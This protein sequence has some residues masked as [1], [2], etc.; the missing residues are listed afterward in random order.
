M[1]TIARVLITTT[2]S[3]LIGL[4]NIV[5]ADDIDIYNTSRFAPY[6]PYET[7]GEIAPPNPNYP[8]ILFIVDASWSM[9]NAD[10]GQV[11][12]R[13]SRLRTAF[14][15]ILANSTGVN[16]ALMRFSHRHSGARVLYP[17]SPI[18]YARDSVEQLVNTLVLD[19]WTPSVHA[20]LEGALYYRGDEVHFGR[21]RTAHVGYR[22]HRNER[23]SRVSHP[24]SYIGGEVV[25]N[26]QCTDANPD[27]A[28]CITE[29]IIGNALY[30]SPIHHACQS[31]HIIF[32]SDGAASEPVDRGLATDLIE[33]G[34]TADQ[35]FTCG[36]EIAHFLA[37]KDQSQSIAG[38]NTVTTHT[39]GFNTSLRSLEN[40]AAAGNGN[41][42]ESSSAAD[43][44]N[45]INE[46]ISGVATPTTILA[47]PSVTIDSESLFAN[48]SDTYLSLFEPA[49]TPVWPGN[50][51]GYWFDGQL[52]DY[53]TPR[54]AALDPST[55]QFAA[56]TQSLWSTFPDGNQI[57]LGGAASKIKGQNSRILVTN[58]PGGTKALLHASNRI[59]ADNM[60]ATQLGLPDASLSLQAA[61]MPKML[62]WAY[63]AD[64]HDINNN[65]NT[66][67]ARNQYADPLHSNPRIVTYGKNTANQ[68]ESVVFFGTNEGYLHAIDTTTGQDLYSF[69]PWSLLENLKISYRNTPFTRK[70]Y[71][72]DGHITIWTSDKNNNGFIDKPDEHA[73]L[74]A[75]MRRGGRNYYALDV[76]KQSAPEI[77]WTITG[78]AGNFIE[79]GQTWSK[80]VRGRMR[81]P[82]TNQITD[83]MVFSGGYDDRQD[84][85]ITRTPDQMGRAMYIVDALSGDLIW[86]A[87]PAGATLNLPE[88]QY[89]IPATPEVIDLDGDGLFDQIYAGDMGGQIWRFDVSKTGAITGGR[90]ADFSEIN[91]AP[92]RFFSTP[93]AVL[94]KPEGDDL[95]L[96]VSIGSGTRSQPLSLTENNA[97]YSIKQTDYAST[98]DG[99]GFKDSSGSYV[100][101]QHAHLVNVTDNKIV[102][103][104]ADER[105]AVALEI[106]E[107]SGWY[108]NMEQAGEKILNP[109]VTANNQVIFTSYQPGE[110][111]LCSID[112]GFS[113]LYQLDIIDGRPVLDSDNDGI[114]ERSDRTSRLLTPGISAPPVIMFAPDTDTN[115]HVV[116]GTESSPVSAGALI[117]RTHW[118]ETPEH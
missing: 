68:Y 91:S 31:N 117:T 93:D 67:E 4:S 43:L 81:H 70:L 54:L 84:D 28:S 52:K 60:N 21:T 11:G 13:I 71:G 57:T 95:Y 99:Y 77:L 39:V 24:E 97:F 6:P 17:M 74:Y 29:E 44:A 69:L 62:Q 47:Q 78:G 79:L 85:V 8:N 83:V 2:L 20:L 12:S 55:G 73:Y 65:G 10:Q 25:R 46:L 16:I 18:E 22:N 102:E 100:P 30:R 32:I 80:M 98:P 9:R 14:T 48:R 26:A 23:F 90:I 111:S 45:A 113:N 35:A 34:C 92:R 112:P 53:S 110:Q 58:H 96:T 38:D 118:A 104:S 82:D 106:K 27:H 33:S 7:D 63:G 3:L 72:M 89:S 87:G 64:V 51:K 36:P 103:G 86:N 56:G 19:W 109:S 49:V 75:G 108:I 76:T 61:D 40:I 66:T 42:Y 115:V 15:E 1:T 59:N 50:L 5:N 105:T 101:L 41:Y 94:V 107:K 116:I 114:K 88:M 37:N